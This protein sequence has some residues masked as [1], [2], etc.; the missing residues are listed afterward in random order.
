MRAL[1]GDRNWF[2]DARN[3]RNSRKKIPSETL[4]MQNKTEDNCQRRLLGSER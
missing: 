4:E 3:T 1:H 2:S